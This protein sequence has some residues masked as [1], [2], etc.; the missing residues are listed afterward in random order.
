M[1]V[2]DLGYDPCPLIP[3][4]KGLCIGVQATGEP[5]YEDASVIFLVVPAVTR[6]SDFPLTNTYNNQ[7]QNFPL[8]CHFSASFRICSTAL[9]VS[10][11]TLKGG[12]LGGSNLP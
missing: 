8:V 11:L 2:T 7:S 3:R 9:T 4:E 1:Y 6:C 12:K 5:G 10:N